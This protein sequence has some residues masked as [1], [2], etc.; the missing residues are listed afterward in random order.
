MIIFKDFAGFEK[1]QRPHPR[2]RAFYSRSVDDYIERSSSFIK[3]DELRTL[4]ANT[5][6]NTI[7]TTA[8]SY[9]KDGKPYTYIITGDIQA[10]WLRDSTAQIWHYFPLLPSAPELGVLFKGLI[11][12]HSECI[13][14]DPYANAFYHDNELEVHER[15]WELDSLVYPMALAAKFWAST[16]DAEPFDAQWKSSISLVLKT[17][18]VQQ[19]FSEHGPYLF[20]RVTENPIDTLSNEG[21]GPPYKT[22]GLIASSFRPSD[23]ACAYPFN[24]AGNLFALV[25]LKQIKKM[26]EELGFLEFLAEVAELIEG[27]SIGLENHALVMHPIFGEIYAYEVDGLGHYICLDDANA[28]SLLSAPF[29]EA[30]ALNSPHYQSTRKFLLSPSNVNFFSG[31]YGNGIGSAHTGPDKIWPMA[32]II[33]AVT[34]QNDAEILECLRTLIASSAGTGLL[35][36]SF[37][38]DD[39]ND[40]TRPWF[41][42]CNS[43][44]GA[45]ISTLIKERPALLDQI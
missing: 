37:N 21:F 24:I 41:A 42:W 7:D 22:T 39:V 27:I 5:F 25:V 30:L 44:F 32:L 15:K 26:L 45:L 29:L 9:F 19:R 40:Y 13:L 6:A 17:M 1:W 3:N 33:Q 12:K 2:D 38:A 31:R 23:D 16:G 28:P 43:L 34:S 10:M 11:R 4:Y 18:K 35:H 8:Y 20:N 36:E 14:K